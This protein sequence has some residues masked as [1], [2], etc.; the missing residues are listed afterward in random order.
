MNFCWKIQLLPCVEHDIFFGVS[1]IFFLIA[2]SPHLH[3]LVFNLLCSLHTNYLRNYHL[4]HL[5]MKPYS[6]S[7]I[8]ILISSWTF[9]LTIWI[10]DINLWMKRYYKS[11]EIWRMGLEMDLIKIL[12]RMKVK[13]FLWLLTRSMWNVIFLK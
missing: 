9:L 6:H 12:W 13:Y 1:W 10:S 8:F 11:I 3:T 5:Q 4:F 2:S 7:F